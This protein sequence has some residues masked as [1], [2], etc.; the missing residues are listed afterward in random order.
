MK[1]FLKNSVKRGRLT[2]VCVGETTKK[3]GIYDH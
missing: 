3:V 2:R 1:I